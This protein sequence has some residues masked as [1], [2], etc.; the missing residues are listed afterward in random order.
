MKDPYIYARCLFTLSGHPETR[1]DVIIKAPKA[2]IEALCQAPNDVHMPDNQLWTNFAGRVITLLYP[3]PGATFSIGC[4][5]HPEGEIPAEIQ[6]RTP[7]GTVDDLAFW[8]L[9]HR[10]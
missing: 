9:S 5:P 7:D 3:L 6:G 8:T 1:F 4:K 10:P 2:K